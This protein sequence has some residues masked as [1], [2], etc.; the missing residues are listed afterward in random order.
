MGRG[1]SNQSKFLDMHIGHTTYMY[2]RLYHMHI[3]QHTYV[4]DYMYHMYIYVHVPWQFYPSHCILSRI[5]KDQYV[6]IQEYNSANT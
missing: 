2:S 1:Q 3:G 4:V 5:V 6:Q